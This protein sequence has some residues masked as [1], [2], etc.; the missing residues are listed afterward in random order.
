MARLILLLMLFSGAV[1]AVVA[2]LAAF[3]LGRISAGGGG[4]GGGGPDSG[5]PSTLRV[6]A[7]VLL[8]LLMLG[9]TTGWLGGA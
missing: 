3:G 4:A 6:V 9:V 5:M 1:L 7:Y 2:L 8:L